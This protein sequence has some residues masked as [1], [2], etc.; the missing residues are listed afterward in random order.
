MVA[1]WQREGVQ[2]SL[3]PWLNQRKPHRRGNTT[4][5]NT[6]YWK[7]RPRAWGHL[8]AYLT[9]RDTV[10]KHLTGWTACNASMGKRLANVTHGA[11]YSHGNAWELPR[12]DQQED[13]YEAIK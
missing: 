1:R 10:A 9:G 4:M 8:G 13:G 3:C 12:R 5:Q 2:P 7:L 6:P 11:V